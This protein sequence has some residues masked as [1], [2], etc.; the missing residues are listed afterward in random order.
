MMA[1]VTELNVLVV[2]LDTKLAFESHIRLKAAAA[3]IKLGI[4]RKASSLYGDTVLIWRCFWSF[5]P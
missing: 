3:S 1:R 5:L 4:M 2:V